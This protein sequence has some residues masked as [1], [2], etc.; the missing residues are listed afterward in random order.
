MTPPLFGC[1]VQALRGV[2]DSRG[3]YMYVAGTASVVCSRFGLFSSS[4]SSS[5]AS[6]ADAASGLINNDGEKDNS[7]IGADTSAVAPAATAAKGVTIDNYSTTLP[8]K[9]GLSS[10][11]AVC[12]LVV[13]ALCLVYGLKLSVPQ[14]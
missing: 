2:M 5:T 1:L 11:A 6:K 12:V 3:F 10:S 9:K 8:L 14:V 7:K 13:R 4:L